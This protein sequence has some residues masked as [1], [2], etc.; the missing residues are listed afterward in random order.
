MKH[1]RE[2]RPQKLLIIKQDTFLNTFPKVIIS[3]IR[4]NYKLMIH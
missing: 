3:V 4:S 1:F 2:D